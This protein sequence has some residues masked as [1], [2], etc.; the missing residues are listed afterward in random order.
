MY[1]IHVYTT[2]ITQ[3]I[4]LCPITTTTITNTIQVPPFLYWCFQGYFIND[5]HQNLWLKISFWKNPT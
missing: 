3:K 5:L 1:A 2:I 4:S